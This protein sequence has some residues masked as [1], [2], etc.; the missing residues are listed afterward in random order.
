MK[1]L[2]IGG[3]GTISSAISRLMIEQGHDLWLLNRGRNSDRIPEG[4]HLLT[5]DIADE[6]TV[7][8]LLPAGQFDCV[9][10]FIAYVPAHIERDCRLFAG[11]TRQYIFIS[12]ASAY[13][14]PARS[15]VV[16]EATPLEN[17]FWQ[18]SRDKI[19][20]EETLRRLSREN[21]FPATIVRPSHTYDERK[22][23]TGVHGEYGS[24]SVVKRIIEGKPVIIQG[25]GESLWTMTHSSDFAR[26]FAGIAGNPKTIGLAVQITSDESLTWNRIYRCMADAVG[27]PLK[28]CHVASDLLAEISPYDLRG[29][30]LGDKAVSVVFDNSL[31]HSLVPDFTT[32]KPFAVGV[33]ETINHIL[34]HPEYQ[35]E[36]AEFDAW[37]DW[38]VEMQKQMATK[39]RG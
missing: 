18:Y 12:S 2:L 8:N 16:S 26:A 28:T 11:R 3:T 15:H 14:K 17:P 38:V 30:L 19:A 22:V 35:T 4:A 31:L 23:P 29:G 1:I 21:G 39:R 10:D 34:A 36:D 25:D 32:Q 13:Q 24:W 27:L 33:A 6:A 7:A 5:A 9:A 20:C 37:C